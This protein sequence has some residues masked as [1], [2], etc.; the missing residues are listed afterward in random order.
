MMSLLC[1][2]EFHLLAEQGMNTPAR[3]NVI[4]SPSQVK[5]VPMSILYV[6]G[7]LFQKAFSFEDSLPK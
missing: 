5:A 2:S 7:I 1:R 3:T 6:L 4:L